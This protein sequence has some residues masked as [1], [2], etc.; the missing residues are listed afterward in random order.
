VS[1]AQEED[2]GP[3]PGT[4]PVAGC[5]RSVAAFAIAIAVFPATVSRAVAVAVAGTSE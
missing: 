3:G 5:R 2:G 4:N 1:T